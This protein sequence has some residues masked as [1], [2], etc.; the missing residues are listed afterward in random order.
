MKL[1]ERT[2]ADRIAKLPFL[3]IRTRR[4]IYTLAL[5]VGVMSEGQAQAF[6]HCNFALQNPSTF[7]EQ[8][9]T[10]HTE[11]GRIQGTL[12]APDD[13]EPKALV[14]MLHGYTGARNENGGMFR[15]TAHAFAEYGIATLR[16][17]FIGSGQSDGKWADT[18]FST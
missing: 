10:V 9:F 12:A 17:D 15:R 14:L 1:L 4:Y 6:D 18:L 7:S 13:T 16:I 3:R 5:L 2:M 11:D 8:D